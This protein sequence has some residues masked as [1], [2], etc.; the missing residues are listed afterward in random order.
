MQVGEGQV[1]PLGVRVWAVWGQDAAGMG[2]E[3]DTVGW[4]QRCRWV[5][6]RAR[7]GPGWDEDTGGWG[8]GCRWGTVRAQPAAEG[9]GSV[10]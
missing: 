9:A 2:P 10:G 6:D 8:R 5:R 1:Q 3:W 7:M 4:G